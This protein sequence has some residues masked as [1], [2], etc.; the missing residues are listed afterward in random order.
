MSKVNTYELITE[1]ISNLLEQ[2]VVPWKQPWQTLYNAQPRNVRGSKYRGVNLFLL[3]VQSLF[4][5]YSCPYW[6]TY[7]QAQELGGNVRRGQKGS[8]VV[9]WK[10]IKEI[11]EDGEEETHCKL[12]SGLTS[13]CHLV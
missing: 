13:H 2:G 5:G 10:Q 3:M 9:F 4:C 11:N 1:Q 8:H 12:P 7:K 6:L